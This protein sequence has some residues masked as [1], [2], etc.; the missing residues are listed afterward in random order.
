M[1]PIGVRS[2]RFAVSAELGR[3]QR[4]RLMLACVTILAAGSLLVIMVHYISNL[5]VVGLASIA[6]MV[7][8]FI[9]LLEVC[10]SAENTSGLVINVW[11]VALVGMMPIIVAGVFL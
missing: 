7:C 10:R 4:N 9:T 3:L 5:W 2:K 11:I 8:L 1:D 6:A